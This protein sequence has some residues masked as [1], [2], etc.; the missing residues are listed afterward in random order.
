MWSCCN[1]IILRLYFS[2]GTWYPDS[3]C[4]NAGNFESS[5]EST[6]SFESSLLDPRTSFRFGLCENNS[7]ILHK[8]CSKRSNLTRFSFSCNGN[9]PDFLFFEHSI[10]CMLNIMVQDMELFNIFFSK[11]LFVVSFLTF[12]LLSLNKF[13]FSKTLSA[14]IVTKEPSN[15]KSSCESNS[16]NWKV[17]S[18]VR[19][20]FLIKH[21]AIL[22]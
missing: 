13:S 19:F 10:Y 5:L 3:T 9:S 12:V 7:S 14:V 15:S 1:Y 20:I 16:S 8:F 2:S 22:D 11:Y 6:L 18:M 4:F 21:S 17:E